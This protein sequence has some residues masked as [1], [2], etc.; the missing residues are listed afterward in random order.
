MGT[1]DYTAQ[2]R[3]LSSVRVL[4]VITQAGRR[5]NGGLESVTKLLEHL[6]GIDW[7][8]LTHTSSS[9]TRRWRELGGDVHVRTNLWKGAPGGMAGGGTK[10]SRFF[11]V[12]RSNVAMW[13]FLGQ[14]RAPVVHFNDIQAF[15][16]MGAGA[17]LAERRIVL[18]VRNVK[19]DG[20]YGLHWHFARLLSH[21]MVLLSRDMAHRFEGRLGGRGL[22]QKL[23]VV[24]SGVD[25]PPGQSAARKEEAEARSGRLVVGDS[26]ANVGYV[27]AVTPQKGQLAFIE[28]TLP[29]LKGSRR[30]WHV[31]FL[32][33]YDPDSDPYSRRCE[34][35]VARL[36]LRGQVTFVGYTDDISGWYEALDVVV[37]A[38]EREGLARSM[39]ESIASGTPVVSFD[40]A[41]AR[42][43]LEA[44]GC[45]LV[46]TARDHPAFA[47]AV[48]DLIDDP[49][50][51][52]VL[53]ERGRRVGR[54][55][56]DPAASADG[57]LR[58]YRSLVG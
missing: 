18:N 33:D 10:V 43:V 52:R 9:Y 56:F 49:E 17:R 58:I 8:V 39:I 32:G 6:K 48:K 51:R 26:V 29:R 30:P 23:E 14:E 20:S 50:R 12:L 57:Y 15:L 13:R 19:D 45:G 1:H 16:A 35:A 7:V 53:G 22:G 27:G 5:A 34:E 11:R 37:V 42:E 46:V 38:S 21:R 25:G 2:E 54:A 41:S 4:F 3:A 36:D 40:V 44:H 47:E 28:E 24:Y 55:L 31:Y